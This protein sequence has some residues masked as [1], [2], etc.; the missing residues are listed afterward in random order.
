[1]KAAHPIQ[2]ALQEVLTKKLSW[3]QWLS[4]ADQAGILRLCL[5]KHN[6]S[7]STVESKQARAAAPHLQGQLRIAFVEALFGLLVETSPF[8]LLVE[9]S[10]GKTSDG[11]TGST[12]TLAAG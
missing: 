8:G 3:K 4:V 7:Y 11:V 5:E 10:G 12:T 1:L 9:T 2:K 6:M